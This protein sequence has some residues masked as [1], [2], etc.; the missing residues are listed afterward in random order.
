MEEFD[1]F[2]I[3][4]IDQLQLMAMMMD[5]VI[6][7]RNEEHEV[8]VEIIVCFA[9][10]FATGRCFTFHVVLLQSGSQNPDTVSHRPP[11]IDGFLLNPNP[12]KRVVGQPIVNIDMARNCTQDSGILQ[13]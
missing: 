11:S 10:P 2:G 3:P 5:G 6:V 1:C 9:V 4:H 7:W 12:C 13:H 8:T